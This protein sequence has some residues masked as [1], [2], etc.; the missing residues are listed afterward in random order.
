MMPL[1]RQFIEIGLYPASGNSE[2]GPP[3]I[4][5]MGHIWMQNQTQIAGLTAWAETAKV[6]DTFRWDTRL[7]DSTLFIC[8]ASSEE[9]KP[10]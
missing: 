1:I 10:Q 8:Y 2:I 5:T 9:A 6:G 7:G 4:R 3:T